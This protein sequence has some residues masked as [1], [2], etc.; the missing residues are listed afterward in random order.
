MDLAIGL[1]CVQ[2]TVI[3]SVDSKLRGRTQALYVL[4]AHEKAKYEFIFTHS[5]HESPRLFTT[6]QTV[7]K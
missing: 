1:E 2:K 3:R 5:L 4:S 7:S 6:V